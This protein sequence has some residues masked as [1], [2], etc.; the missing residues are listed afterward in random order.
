MTDMLS[1]LQL[2]KLNNQEN[3]STLVVLNS[4]VNVDK[5]AEEFKEYKGK[6]SLLLDGDKAGTEAN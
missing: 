5:F 4:V 6:I 1:F 3:K 2:Q